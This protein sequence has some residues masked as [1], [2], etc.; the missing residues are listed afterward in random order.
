MSAYAQEHDLANSH[1]VQL[2]PAE[3]LFKGVARDF[4]DALQQYI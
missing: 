2:G 3:A 1:V 4:R